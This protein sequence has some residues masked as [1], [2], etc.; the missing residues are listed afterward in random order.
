MSS[1]IEMLCSLI[2]RTPSLTNC[3]RT[4]VVMLTMQFTDYFVH[5]LLFSMDNFSHD[6]P[7]VQLAPILMR[8]RCHYHHHNHYQNHFIYFIAALLAYRELS[9]IYIT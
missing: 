5:C 9:N 1:V 8:Y 3:I 2:S 4:N 7:V 6:A